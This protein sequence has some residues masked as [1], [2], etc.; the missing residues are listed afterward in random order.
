MSM[1]PCKW[2]FAFS[3]HLHA[4]YVTVTCMP[5]CEI[6]DVLPEGSMHLRLHGKVV[7][8]ASNRSVARTRMAD[9]PI[10]VLMAAG[11]RGARCGAQHR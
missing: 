11:A 8:I 1:Q 2:T 4:G 7:A 10:E 5:R 6:P 3:W 9:V